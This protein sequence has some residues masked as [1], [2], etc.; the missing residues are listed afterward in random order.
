MKDN[1]SLLRHKLGDFLKR[2]AKKGQSFVELA[3]I[4]PILI[5]M[6]LGIAEVSMFIGRYLDLLDLTREAAR[7]ASI[8][9]PFALEVGVPSNQVTTLIGEKDCSAADNSQVN[10]F[11]KAACYFSPP[12]DGVC[13]NAKF[14]RG[15]NRY[16][17]FDLSEDDVVISAYT[18]SGNTIQQVWPGPNSPGHASYWALSTDGGLTYK[19]KNGAVQQVQADRW[20]YDCQGNPTGSTAPYYTQALVQSQINPNYSAPPNNGYVAVEVYY[21]YHQVLAIPIFNFIPNPLRIHAFTLMPLPNGQPTD[22]PQSTP[23][24]PSP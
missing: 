16:V 6:L 14:C 22:V 18:I 8:D 20:K 10:F 15:F 24:S 1:W 21:C 13:Q 12:S 17:D 11:Y 23:T 3:L 5:V 2:P 19:D 4:L 7:E 9:D